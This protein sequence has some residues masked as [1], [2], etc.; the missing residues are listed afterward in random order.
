VTEDWIIR[1]IQRL[2]HHNYNPYAVST[3][4]IHSLHF[5]PQM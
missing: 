2:Y 3:F 4:L 1:H 5:V